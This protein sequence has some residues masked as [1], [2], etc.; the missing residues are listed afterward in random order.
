MKIAWSDLNNVREA[1]RYPFRDGVI[2]VL[3]IEIA[4]WRSNPNAIFNLMRKNP[5]RDQIEYVLGTL[6]SPTADMFEVSFVDLNRILQ[7]QT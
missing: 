3:E 6:G 1:G 4:I 2:T 7:R 5:I